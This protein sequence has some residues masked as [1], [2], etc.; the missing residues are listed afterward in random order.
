MI[1]EGLNKVI[2]RFILPQFSWITGYRVRIAHENGL[3]WVL[4]I[5]YPESDEKDFFNEEGFFVHEGFREA[6]DLTHNVFKMMGFNRDIRF[7]GVRF[8]TKDKD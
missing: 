5:Y 3:D 7:E 2:E 4:V 8:E 1:K 6:E